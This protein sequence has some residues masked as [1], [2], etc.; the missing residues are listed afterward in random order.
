[1]INFCLSYD[2]LYAHYTSL[3]YEIDLIYFYILKTHV[4]ILYT[5]HCNS[6]TH[7]AVFFF[8]IFCLLASIFV[9]NVQYTIRFVSKQVDG[10]NFFFDIH[11]KGNRI[12]VKHDKKKILTSCLRL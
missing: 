3:L 7:A 4:Y 9:E 11:K 1:M 2:K 10:V 12:L 6:I 8:F 5:L